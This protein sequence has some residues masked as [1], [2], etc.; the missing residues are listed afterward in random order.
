MRDRLHTLRNGLFLAHLAVCGILG[1]LVV[2][3][4]THAAGAVFVACWLLVAL[5]IA[6][7]L[8]IPVQLFDY[9]ANNE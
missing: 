8:W 9:F 5:M 2:A 1:W 7:V 4:F 6:R 3:R